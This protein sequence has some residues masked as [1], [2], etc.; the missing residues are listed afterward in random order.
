MTNVKPSNEKLKERS[1]RIL[2]AETH[3][4]EAAASDLMN[5]AN[6]DLRAAIVVQ[7]TNVSFETAQKALQA[8]Q[9]IIEKAIDSVK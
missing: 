2:M 4:D 1:L 5:R 3:L 9:N 8:H 7:K 6:G